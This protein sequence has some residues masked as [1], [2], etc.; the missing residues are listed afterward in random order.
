MTTKSTLPPAPRGRPK[1]GKRKRVNIS[2]T[3]SA[4]T[5]DYIASYRK[6]TKEPDLTPGRIFDRLVNLTKGAS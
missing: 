1:Q 4:D 3:I 6:A 2:T 5:H